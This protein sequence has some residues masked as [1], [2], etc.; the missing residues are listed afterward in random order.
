MMIDIPWRNDRFEAAQQDSQC[1]EGAI[2]GAYTVEG[3]TYTSENN[4]LQSIS[5]VSL[6]PHSNF[7][8]NVVDQATHH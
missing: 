2:I 6:Q 8:W 7:F 4:C 5:S 3:H 1:Y